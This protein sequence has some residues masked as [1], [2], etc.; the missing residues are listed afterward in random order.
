[1]GGH[2]RRPCRGRPRGDLRHRRHGARRLQ[3]SPLS[4]DTVD[5]ISAPLWLFVSW[6][7]WNFGLPRPAHWEIITISDRLLVE[8]MLYLACT[9]YALAYT[10]RAARSRRRTRRRTDRCASVV[11]RRAAE[12]LLKVAARRWPV[13][14]REDLRREWAAEL[15]I[16]DE[17]GRWTK[18]LGFALSLAVSRAGAPV[19]DRRLLRGQARRTALALLLSPIACVAIVVGSAVAMN[20]LYT[21]L[22]RWGSGRRGRNCRSGRR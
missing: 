14:V 2:R 9:P 20:L 11:T 12:L 10:I 5:G 6:T 4:P 19:V 21:V 13:D 22:T 15:H 18:V 8:P 17:T 1:M 16:L 7:E 3:R